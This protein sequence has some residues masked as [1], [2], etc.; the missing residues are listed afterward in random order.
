[1]DQ[2][3]TSSQA[4]DRQVGGSHYKDVEGICPHCKGKIQH[5][6]LY[7]K[8]PYLIGNATKYI[9]RALL[10][11]GL[12]DVEKAMHYI[13]KIIEVFFPDKIVEMRLYDKSSQ[14]QDKP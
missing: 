8:S 7:A 13:Q 3:L 10:K 6:D 1:M 14:S 2:N 4:N 12:Q 5:W 11:N 9:T